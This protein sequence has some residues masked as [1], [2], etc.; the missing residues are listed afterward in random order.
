MHISNS[1]SFSKDFKISPTP[2]TKQWHKLEIIQNN[3]NGKSMIEI[4]FNNVITHTEE[5]LIPQDYTN[6][7][8]YAG[9]KFYNANFDGKIRNLQVETWKS[10]SPDEMVTF[11]Q[12]DL[13]SNSLDEVRDNSVPIA[14]ESS[15][16]DDYDNSGQINEN[17]VDSDNSVQ[18][19]DL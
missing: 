13:G 14:G 10:N 12:F 2:A 19:A 15:S 8:V 11:S 1:S 17:D 18:I 3:V 16:S 7:R 5:N 6:V 4:K 9:S